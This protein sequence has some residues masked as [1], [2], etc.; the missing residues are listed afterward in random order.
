MTVLPEEVEQALKPLLRAIAPFGYAM[1]H[2]EISPSFGNFLVEFKSGGRSLS[3]AYD[4]LQ[5]MVQGSQSELE[6]AGLWRGFGSVEHLESFLMRWLQSRD[7]QPTVQP[8]VPAS[9]RSSG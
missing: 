9:G 2:V 3:I 4:R 6:P 8:E 1:S 5:F 7:A